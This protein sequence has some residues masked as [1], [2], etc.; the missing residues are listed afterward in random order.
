MTCLLEPNVTDAVLCQNV[1][2]TPNG[3]HYGTKI[4]VTASIYPSW[5]AERSDQK[6]KDMRE[7][8]GISRRVPTVFGS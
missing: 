7:D 1:G 6:A 2:N 8:V 4:R 3:D 5:P